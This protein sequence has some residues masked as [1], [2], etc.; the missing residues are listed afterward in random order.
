MRESCVWVLIADRRDA[1]LCLSAN[2]TTTDG[3][4]LR[5]ALPPVD[6]SFQFA[7]EIMARLELGARQNLYDGLIIVAPALMM[8]LLRHCLT[9]DVER[10]L[11]SQIVQPDDFSASASRSGV[12]SGGQSR[13]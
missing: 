11:I 4:S 3:W 10:L 13:K 5:N 6:S 12:G 8:E 2:G 7:L 9:P 1:F